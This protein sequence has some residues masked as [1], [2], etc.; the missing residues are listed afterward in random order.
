[1]SR[2]TNH[3]ILGSLNSNKRITFQFNGQPYE[4][5]EH[6]TIAAA[7]LANGIRTLR[8]HEDSGTP[9]GIY[10]N[11]GHC[12]ECRVNVNSQMN[13]RACLTVVEDNMIVESGKQHPNIVREMVKKR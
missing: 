6:E 8:V 2:I 10:C 11:I 3:P 1:M 7:L 5:Y 13:V 4:A 9:R 12:S